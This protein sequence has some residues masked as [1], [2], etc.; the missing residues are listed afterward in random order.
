MCLLSVHSEWPPLPGWG[1]YLLAEHF[2]PPKGEAL[3]PSFVILNSQVQ[4]CPPTPAHLK[5]ISDLG[6]WGI[7]DLLRTTHRLSSPHLPP[8][9]VVSLAF[10]PMP[11]IC[12]PRDTPICLSI[13][14]EWAGGPQ[15]DPW[16]VAP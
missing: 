12:A 1:R 6:P 9:E 8:P 4:K 5:L 15:L 13:V 10:V 11:P 14:P 16:T 7:Q 2:C 3:A